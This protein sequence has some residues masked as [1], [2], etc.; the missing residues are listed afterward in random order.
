MKIKP[1]LRSIALLGGLLIPSTLSA[2]EV[3][4]WG[5]FTILSSSSGL[6]V[7]WYQP[8]S[9]IHQLP[10]F[11]LHP[12][13][14]KQNIMNARVRMET[15]VIYFYPEKEMTVHARVTF[16][17]GSITERFPAASLQPYQ[18]TPASPM[19]F[20]P[21]QWNIASCSVRPASSNQVFDQRLREF[22]TTQAPTVTY[23][24]GDLLPPHHAD[25]SLIPAVSGSA[26]A[27]YG[28]ARAVPDAW[29]FRSQAHNPQVA[30]PQLTASTAPQ[31]KPQVEKFIFYRGAG[32]EVP[33]YYA[34]MRDDNTVT[35]SNHSA[36]A[37]TFQI[38]LR[39]RDGRASWKQMPNICGPTPDKDRSATITFPE[40]TMPVEQADRE[41]SALFVKELIANGLT[42]AEAEA[43]IATWNHT[44]FTEPGQRVFTIVD[45]TWVDS[46]LP[47]AI[48]PE[49]KKIERVFVA[50]YEVLAPKTEQA[51]TRLIESPASAQRTQEYASLQLGRFSRGASAIIADR[52]RDTALH[53]FNDLFYQHLQD[54]QDRAKN[55]QTSATEP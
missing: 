12:M 34:S 20:A 33:P 5:T 1:S 36:S 17:N 47:L 42:K 45:R 6:P 11:T 32:Q 23:W 43:M 28:A 35:F 54:E 39:V 38:A 37:S 19:G 8:Y 41:L 55:P 50:R 3:H 27:H 40:E 53:Q 29:L 7:D 44:W 10:P 14:M 26:G 31:P 21:G 51:L 52:K 2:L 4:E 15:P 25:A 9:D 48:A 18:T 49:P 22:T 30:T 46:V 24:T 13:L 16:R